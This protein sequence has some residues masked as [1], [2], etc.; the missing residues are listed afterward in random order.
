[1]DQIED[2][3]RDLQQLVALLIE[4]NRKLS[5]KVDKLE[6]LIESQNTTSIKLNESTSDK[7]ESDL[8]PENVNLHLSHPA[9]VNFNLYSEVRKP[10]T[11]EELIHMVIEN[12][13]IM[14]KNKIY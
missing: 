2:I 10:T 9:L 1:M 6:Q 12:R 5:I 4:Q 14:I 3:N 13:H 11:L 7:S 8:H